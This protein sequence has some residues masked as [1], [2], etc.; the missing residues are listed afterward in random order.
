M[1]S[2]HD[3]RTT[4]GRGVHFGARPRGEGQGIGSHH[5][6]PASLV[7]PGPFL[8]A[9]LARQ[10]V[11]DVASSSDA[12]CSVSGAAGSAPNSGRR[13][14]SRHRSSNRPSRRTNER[15][16]RQLVIGVIR[17]SFA[18]D[19]SLTPVRWNSRI[20]SQETGHS[21]TDSRRSHI[22]RTAR[23]TGKGFA[24]LRRD[25]VQPRHGRWY[26]PCFPYLP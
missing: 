22:P 18:R 20:S 5:G 21:A 4:G 17:P 16:G 6:A 26:R 14:N 10:R 24:A 11:D 7:A 2:E 15:N 19:T 9:P 8:L 25:D 1:V 3:R 13:T 23:S 12:A